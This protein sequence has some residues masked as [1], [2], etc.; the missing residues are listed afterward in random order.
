MRDRVEDVSLRTLAWVA[1]VAAAACVAVGAWLASWWAGWK[2]RHRVD[3]AQR[4]EAAAERILGDAG[5]RVVARQVTGEWQMEVDGECV[6]VGVRADLVVARGGRRYVA[7][8][9]TGERAP[10]PCYPPTR[11]QLLEY[12]LVFDADE[13]LLVDVPARVVR[14]VGFPEV[15]RLPASA[16]RRRS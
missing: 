1:L 10:D 12:G 6:T 4:G 14:R 15:P 13:V 3:L 11:R 2:G 5:Y 16:S 7:E 9:K 8:V